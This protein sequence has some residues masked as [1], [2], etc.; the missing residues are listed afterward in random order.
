MHL[1]EGIVIELHND[2]TGIFANFTT[3]VQPN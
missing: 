3:H 2:K 1:E